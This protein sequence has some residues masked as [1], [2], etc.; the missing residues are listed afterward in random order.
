M[1]I[2]MTLFIMQVLASA[3]LASEKDDHI[4]KVLKK[5]SQNTELYIQD[6]T[7]IFNINGYACQWPGLKIPTFQTMHELNHNKP[8][9]RIG[10]DDYSL[11][12]G[13]KDPNLQFCKNLGSA[14]SVFGKEFITGSKLPIKIT[15]L[16]DEREGLRTD[17]QGN[18]TLTNLIHETITVELNG[19]I[20]ESSAEINLESNR[21]SYENN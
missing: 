9:V 4:L 20:V 7:F 12:I 21:I 6:D 14:Q 13:L 15:R 16:L 8:Y 19:R 18:S 5:S 17:R 3:S 2:L 1:K 11:A 10:G